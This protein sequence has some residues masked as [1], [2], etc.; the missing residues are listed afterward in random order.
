M[1]VMY[2]GREVSHPR[3]SWRPAKVVA[4]LYGL[5]GK[6]PYMC[7]PNN[8]S[9]DSTDLRDHN[10]SDTCLTVLRLLSP[11]INHRRT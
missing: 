3:L 7:V 2:S 5:S 1:F 9:N 11:G 8:S 10:M 4:G 6:L